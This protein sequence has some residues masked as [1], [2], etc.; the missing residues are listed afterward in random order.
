MLWT[1]GIIGALVA[2]IV[3]LY[4]RLVGLRN[5]SEGAWSDIDVQLRRHTT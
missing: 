3:V 5:R 1:V 2:G 4:N